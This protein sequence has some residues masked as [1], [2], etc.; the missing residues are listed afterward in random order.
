M[1][2][3]K[4]KV[5]KRKVNR[6]VSRE[7]F[8]KWLA[9]NHAAATELFVSFYKKHTGKAGAT[10][11]EAVE[12]ALRYGW[13]DGVKKRVGDEKFMY[14]VSPRKANSTWSW[15]NVQRAIALIDAG[16]MAAPG[17][18][19]FEAREANRNLHL[20]MATPWSKC[21][22]QKAVYEGRQSLE[23]FREPAAGLPETCRF[24]GIEGQ[25]RRDTAASSCKAYQG[26]RR[27]TAPEYDVSEG[28]PI[29]I[30]SDSGKSSY[31]RA[32]S[33][34]S[35]QIPLDFRINSTSSRAAPLPPFR[36]VV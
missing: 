15:I 1:S 12:E 6:F 2:R 4:Q 27:R 10:Y 5:K 14:R 35:S 18:K 34:I 28:R 9:K 11:D 36:T 30:P 33:I 26:F 25:T 13:I 21:N 32:L 3:T 7:E 23:V 20:R 22:R 24:L 31:A 8:R 16:K 17:L 29:T 19:A